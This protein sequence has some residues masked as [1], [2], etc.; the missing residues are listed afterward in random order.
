MASS[1]YFTW[2]VLSHNKTINMRLKQLCVCVVNLFTLPE[3]DATYILKVS[4]TLFFCYCLLSRGSHRKICVCVGD[5]EREG[6]KCRSVGR[7][8]V[9]TRS[10]CLKLRVLFC[11]CTKGA[12]FLDTKNHFRE[13]QNLKTWLV[14]PFLF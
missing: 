8:K 13:K 7:T 1:I 10:S 6:I 14:A 3:A 12:D 4:P 9:K 5:R 2:L 11:F